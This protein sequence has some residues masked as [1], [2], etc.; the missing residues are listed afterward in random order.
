MEIWRE[1]FRHV[2]IINLQGLLKCDFAAHVK[3]LSHLSPLRNIPS[4]NLLFLIVGGYVCNI[5]VDYA[6][7][8]CAIICCCTKVSTTQLNHSFIYICYWLLAFYVTNIHTHNHIGSASKGHQTHPHWLVVVSVWVLFH[9]SYVRRMQEPF[10][11]SAL[12][13]H[14]APG[15]FESPPLLKVASTLESIIL[16]WQPAWCTHAHFLQDQGRT[17]ISM[18]IPV[19]NKNRFK[20]RVW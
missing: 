13:A 9:R 8:P 11:E 18:C 2:T 16:H 14:C 4:A 6:V 12:C 3:K 7:F 1:A 19:I 15:N 5:H 17:V 10:S 20:V